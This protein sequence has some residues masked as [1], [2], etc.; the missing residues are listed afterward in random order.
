MGK[1]F[2]MDNPVW[3]AMGKFADLILLNCLFVICC[4]PVFTIG[5]S[6]TAL[7]Y[8]TIRMARKEEGYITRDFFH[9]F[10]ENFK[11]A[12]IIW[13]LFLAVFLVFA[14]DYYIY[15]MFPNVIP[16]VIIVVIMAV[17]MVAFVTMMYVFPLLSRF[18]NTIKNT[19]KNAFLISLLH[20]P[21]TVLLIILLLLPI[22]ALVFLFRFAP[23]VI[24]V[25]ISVPAYWASFIWKSIFAKLE[26][27]EENH[28]D[29]HED[30]GKGESN[31]KSESNEKRDNND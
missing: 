5:A 27:P 23:F 10:K 12:T 28:A 13:F 30:L 26:K 6:W 8:V 21:H 15:S 17:A 14:L 2:N 18:R 11:Q 25:G 16:K 20:I 19:I 24:M 4:L 9:S 31:E 3:V 22:V 29:E 7:Y 1:L